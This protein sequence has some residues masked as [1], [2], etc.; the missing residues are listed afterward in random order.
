MSTISSYG[1]ELPARK[2]ILLTLCIPDSNGNKATDILHINKILKFYNY[3]SESNE[4][5]F[6]NFNLGA[7]SFEV[8]E[9]I[10]ILQEYGF[11]KQIQK[12]TYILSPKG[13]EV[14]RELLSL[15]Q[16]KIIKDLTFSKNLLND[17]TFDELLYY[18]YMKFPDTQENST[19]IIRLK[20]MN[21]GL[22]RRLFEKNKIDETTAK[23]WE[24]R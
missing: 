8:E 7:V 5:K 9:N 2:L 10:E 1:L 18:M 3:I 17:M 23:L 24:K 16:S 14:S 4:I 19:Q 11:L 6:S 21:K 13:E 12:D 20:K 22:I 15:T